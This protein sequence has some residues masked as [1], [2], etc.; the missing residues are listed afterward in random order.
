MQ[1]GESRTEALNNL[2]ESLRPSED[3]NPYGIAPVN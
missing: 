1:N 2:M 3:F